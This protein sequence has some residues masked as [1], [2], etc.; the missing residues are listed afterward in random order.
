MKRVYYASGSVLTG[1]RMAEAIVRYAGA[2]AL[3]EISDTIDIPISLG[4]GRTARAQLLIGPASQLVVVPEADAHEDPEDEATIEDLSIRAR[5]LSSPRPQA[6]DGDSSPYYAM[7]DDY[8]DAID[9][10]DG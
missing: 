8:T 9:D 4:G 2:L 6:S 10:V 3:R 1:D 5:R 7:G